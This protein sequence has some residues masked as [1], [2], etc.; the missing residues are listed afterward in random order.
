MIDTPFK[1]KNTVYIR[2][3]QRCRYQDMIL[4]IIKRHHIGTFHT[5]STEKN[6]PQLSNRIRNSQ[7]RNNGIR[8]DGFR[9][10]SYSPPKPI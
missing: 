8:I 7:N 4:R 3:L 6:T 1:D 5:A 9:R 10:P 2:G